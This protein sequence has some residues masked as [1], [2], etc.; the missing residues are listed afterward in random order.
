MRIDRHCCKILTKTEINCEFDVTLPEILMMICSRNSLG[1]SL[2][3]S[4]D[5]RETQVSEALQT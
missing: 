5:R 3:V 1:S 2:L 4:I